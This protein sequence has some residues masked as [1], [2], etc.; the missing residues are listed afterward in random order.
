MND[1]VMQKLLFGTK[2][3]M[4]KQVY[5]NEFDVVKLDM[6]FLKGFDTNEKSKVIMKSVVDM[7]LSIG[8]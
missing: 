8:M 2:K 5:G 6:A 3:G 4:F 7:A 1:L